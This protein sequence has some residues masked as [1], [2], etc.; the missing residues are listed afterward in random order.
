MRGAKRCVVVVDMPFGS[1]EE[2]P[3][4]AYRNAARIM[5]ETGCQA[6]KIES[7][8]YAANTVLFLVERGIPVMAHV[9]LRPQAVNVQGGFAARGRTQEDRSDI[10]EAAKAVDGAGAFSIVVEGV[11]ET[12]ARA[13]TEAV[14]A[15]TIGIGASVACDGQILVTND[16]LGQFERVPR[17]VKRYGA[18][19]DMIRE[20]V[21]QYADDVRSRRFPNED[22]VYAPRK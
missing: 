15:P 17:F 3:E 6:V 16:M 7:G 18:M 10:I 9:G 12:L 1:Y 8:A 11:E 4:Q 14:H 20:A 22:H 2:S 19:A 5:A 13:I 21:G